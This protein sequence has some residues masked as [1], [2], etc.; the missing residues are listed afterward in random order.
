V[1]V[2]VVLWIEH[3]GCFFGREE[4]YSTSAN[5]HIN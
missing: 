3:K 5:L 4:M 1:C 2:K